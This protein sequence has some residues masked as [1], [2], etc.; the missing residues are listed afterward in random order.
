MITLKFLY[1]RKLF[2][3]E[4]MLEFTGRFRD[5]EIDKEDQMLR[6]ALV[7]LQAIVV[8]FMSRTGKSINELAESEQQLLVDRISPHVKFEMQASQDIYKGV[9]IVVSGGGAFFVTNQEGS[10]LGG[11]I[12]LPG[13]VITGIV[14]GIA[15]YP[16]PSREVIFRTGRNDGIPTYDQSLSAVVLIEDAKLHSSP[17][18]DGIFQTSHDLS[19]FNVVIP[20][21]YGMDIRMADVDV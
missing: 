4:A 20:V 11:Q 16:V 7:D 13:E 21:V 6:S 2:Y 5:D 10:L 14:S 19:E 17:S 8:D 12:T 18:S 9:P 15:V 3:N 1:I